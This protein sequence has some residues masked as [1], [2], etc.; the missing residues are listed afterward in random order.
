MFNSW[1]FYCTTVP[2]KKKEYATINTGWWFQLLWKI[3]VSSDDYSHS[4]VPNHQT[5][6]YPYINH[7]DQP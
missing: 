4:H 6:N 2:S 1:V 7:I 3:L 5:V